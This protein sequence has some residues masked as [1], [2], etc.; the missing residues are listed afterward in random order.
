M[1]SRFASEADLAFAFRAHACPL[2]PMHDRLEVEVPSLLGIAD[3]ILA[4]TDPLQ[5]ERRIASELPAV[6][7][8]SGAQAVAGIANGQDLTERVRAVRH[9]RA[10]GHIREVG[11]RL[12][13]SPALRDAYTDIIAVELKLD[14]WRRADAQA[15]R[16]RTYA[17]RSYVALPAERITAKIEEFFSRGSVGLIAVEE[18][19]RIV[20]PARLA[21]PTEPWRRVLVSEELFARLMARGIPRA[22]L[23]MPV[24]RYP[25][26]VPVPSA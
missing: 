3:V 13:L 11:G 19:A 22:T 2:F 6:L 7:T 25:R 9:L 18:T 4:R 1:S 24:S 15:E 5:L 26:S 16:Y 20:V 8:Q 23:G 21:P 17:D 14:D 12:A 10:S